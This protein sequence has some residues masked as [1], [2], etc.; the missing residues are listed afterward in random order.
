MYQKKFPDAIN[1]SHL[2]DISDHTKCNI[3]LWASPKRIIKNIFTTGDDYAI[4]ANFKLKCD[5]LEADDGDWVT[6]KNLRLLLNEPIH[7]SA[8]EWRTNNDV[9]CFEDFSEL[10]DYKL[11]KK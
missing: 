4:T 7:N 6:L 2:S 9:K 3:K 10:I 8:I 1:K 5:K 11:S